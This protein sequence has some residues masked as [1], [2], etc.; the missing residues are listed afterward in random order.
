MKLLPPD[1]APLHSRL[2]AALR[3]YGSGVVAFSAG[4]DSTVVAMAARLA[5]GERAVAVTGVSD[6]LAAGE[7]E[8]AKELAARIGIRHLV[9]ETDEFANPAYLQNAS[10][11][12]Y[13]CKTELY[14]RLETVCREQGLA[15]IINGANLDDL[16]DYRPGMTAAAEHAVRSPLVECGIDKAGVRALAAAWDLPVWD[17]PAA[18]CLSSRVAYGEAV[19]P[20]RLRMID[21]AERWLRERGF[22]TVRVRY[23]PGDLA[24]VEVLREEL[25][26]LLAAPAAGEL[27][28]HEALAGEL[29]R[30]GFKFVTVDLQ[31][32]RSG[33]QNALLPIVQS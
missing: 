4:V 25:P 27:S 14:S 21:A 7:L 9:L 28:L 8:Q 33:S 29:T 26:R 17:K 22:G 13:H 5:L 1:L 10:D 11:R 24:R 20:E 23:H 16:G 30:L 6:S 15:V 31:G 2:L 3:G 19:T 12:C 32:F 18:P